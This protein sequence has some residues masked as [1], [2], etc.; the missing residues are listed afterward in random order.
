M[1]DLGLLIDN[2]DVAATG[3]AVSHGAAVAIGTHAALRLSVLALDA[4]VELVETWRRL[5]TSLGI[6]TTS[7]LPWSELEPFLKMD[8]KRDQHGIGWVLLQDVGQ[9]V[10]GVRLPI[11]AA[12]RMWTEHV[13]VPG[14]ATFAETASSVHPRVLVLF[15]VNLIGGLIHRAVAKKNQP[16]EEE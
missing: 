13:Y 7:P 3:G 12:E 14:D 2:A 1:T 4:P 9:S 11:E 5:C 10:T 8:K 6:V 15:G 16:P